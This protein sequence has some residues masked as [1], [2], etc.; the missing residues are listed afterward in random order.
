MTSVASEEDADVVQRRRVSAR[1][2]LARNW[3]CGK[4]IAC[5]HVFLFAT[6][7]AKIPS[8]NIVVDKKQCSIGWSTR[9]VLRVH[10]SRTFSKTLPWS[11][12]VSHTACL[13]Q[14]SISRI[15][16]WTTGHWTVLCRSSSTDSANMVT[17]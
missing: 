13:L 15:G 7:S 11:Q 16:S 17:E 1:S 4:S 9:M 3:L 10:L 2:S 12:E 5:H 8:G 14:S 6:F